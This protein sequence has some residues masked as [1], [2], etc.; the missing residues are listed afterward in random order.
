MRKWS[1]STVMVHT[2]K[3]WPQTSQSFSLRIA[4]HI[5][6]LMETCQGRLLSTGMPESVT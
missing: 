2:V 3:S 5:I 6:D 1:V 4:C